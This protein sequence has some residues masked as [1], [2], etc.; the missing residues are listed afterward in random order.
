MICATC[1]SAE[2]A[3]VPTIKIIRAS[4]AFV[5]RADAHLHTPRKERPMHREIAYFPRDFIYL[6]QNADDIPI[7]F[8]SGCAN[9]ESFCSTEL[10]SSILLLFIRMFITTYF[11]VQ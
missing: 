4:G 2:K 8:V 5:M 6:F 10:D 9:V 1:L 7:C 11:L 3:E